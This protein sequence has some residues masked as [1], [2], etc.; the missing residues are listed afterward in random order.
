MCLPR[1]RAFA[2]VGCILS[3][4]AAA[5]AQVQLSINGSQSQA[6]SSYIY[7][8][9]DPTVVPNATFVRLGGNRW[10]AYNWENNYSNAG[11]DY[12]FENDGFLSSSRSPGAAV[13][14]ND[15]RWSCAS[16]SQVSRDAY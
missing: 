9:N 7:G 3:L 15:Q 8:T 5:Q 12:I 16:P 6:I 4:A 10:T 13:L 14:R 1:S 2:M 11:S